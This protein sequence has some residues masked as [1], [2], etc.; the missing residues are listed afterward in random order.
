MEVNSYNEGENKSVIVCDDLLTEEQLNELEKKC[1]S[2]GEEI[3]T[4]QCNEHLVQTKQYNETEFYD[5]L[6]ENSLIPNGFK[7][8]GNCFRIIQ[9]IGG[10]IYPHIDHDKLFSISLYLNSVEKGGELEFYLNDQVVS[11]PPKRNRFVMMTC[12]V[13]HWTRPVTKGKR[14]SIQFFVTHM[15]EID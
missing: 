11:I 13:L 15:S 3:P 6:I 12:N 5:I 9:N 8:S 10:Q 7:Y 4:D 2:Q 1:E 14:K